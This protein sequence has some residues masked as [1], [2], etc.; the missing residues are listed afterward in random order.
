MKETSQSI[1]SIARSDQSNKINPV[2]KAGFYQH[3]QSPDI[4]RS[5]LFNHRYE[6]IYIDKSLIPQ[7]SMILDEATLF[8]SKLIDIKNIRT[9]FWFNHMPMDAI[10]LPHSH[11]DY[12]E[13]LSAVYYISVPEDSGD[14]LLHDN[15]EIITITPEEGMFVF[16]KPDLVHEVSKNNST[17]DRLS[18]GINFGVQNEA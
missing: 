2:L 14:L 10:T 3:Y 18:I 8:A 6:N 9:G 16:F 4:K 17:A 11:D 1:Y 15:D 5:H 12:D 7:I 13:L